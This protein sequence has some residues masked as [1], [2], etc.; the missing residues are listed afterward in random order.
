MIHGTV[1]SVLENLVADVQGGIQDL[2]LVL[3]VEAGGFA[4]PAGLAPYHGRPPLLEHLSYLSFRTDYRQSGR[5]ANAWI[6][7]P[8]ALVPRILGST[9]EPAPD[10][11]QEAKERWSLGMLLLFRPHRT[12]AKLRAPGIH[13]WHA[14]WLAWPGTE[15][16][17]RFYRNRALRERALHVDGLMMLS[18]NAI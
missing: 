2:E 10:A 17:R 16:S 3:D 15:E 6:L 18:F 14:A 4:A 1:N 5:N 11:S 9:T 13:S 7:R 12:C 8:Q